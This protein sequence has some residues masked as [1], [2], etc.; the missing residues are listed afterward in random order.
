MGVGGGGGVVF[1]FENRPSPSMCEFLTGMHRGLQ[2]GLVTSLLMVD[3]DGL[4]SYMYAHLDYMV[5]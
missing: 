4:V 5:L 2:V 1:I 3:L